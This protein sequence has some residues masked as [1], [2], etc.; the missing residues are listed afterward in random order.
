MQKEGVGGVLA[1]LENSPWLPRFAFSRHERY[2]LRYSI[3]LRRSASERK[4]SGKMK[5]IYSRTDSNKNNGALSV[6]IGE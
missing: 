6:R 1:T 2:C 5:P 4:R 3:A